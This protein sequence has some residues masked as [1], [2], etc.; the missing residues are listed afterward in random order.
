MSYQLEPAKQ[1]H[2]L[3]VEVPSGAQG[4]EKEN[5]ESATKILGATDFPKLNIEEKNSRP[6]YSQVQLHLMHFF[7]HFLP[8]HQIFNSIKWFS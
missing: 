4:V 3:L 7:P 2:K 1:Q 5:Q 8:L 6:P